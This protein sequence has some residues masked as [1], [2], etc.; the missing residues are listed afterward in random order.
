MYYYESEYRRQ[1]C[2]ERI[3]RAR[4]EYRRCQAPPKKSEQR[5][6]VPVIWAIWERVRRQA[7]QRAPAYRS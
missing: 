6:R 2:R 7:A 3:A 1:Y 5:R 4:E